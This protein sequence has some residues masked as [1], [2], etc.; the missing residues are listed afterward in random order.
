M[1]HVIGNEFFNIYTPAERHK[2]DDIR[3]VLISIHRFFAMDLRSFCPRLHPRGRNKLRVLYQFLN[4][5]PLSTPR[6]WWLRHHPRISLLRNPRHRHPRRP[7]PLPRP[8]NG[9]KINNTIG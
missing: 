9:I 8:A 5:K 1:D 2:N 6:R 3:F 4:D 7:H